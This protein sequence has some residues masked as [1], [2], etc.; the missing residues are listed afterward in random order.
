[1]TCFL[2][3]QPTEDSSAFLPLVL[4][5]VVVRSLRAEYAP[6]AGCWSC[7]VIEIVIVEPLILPCSTALAE[8]VST[9]RISFLPITG[10]TLNVSGAGAVAN[11]FS[12][13]RAAPDPAIDFLQ[14]LMLA[15]RSSSLAV[16]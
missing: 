4:E 5:I 1:M 14:T 13:A 12:S 15:I 7:G 9:N 10:V 11:G 8:P 6:G 2:D 3:L 16:H